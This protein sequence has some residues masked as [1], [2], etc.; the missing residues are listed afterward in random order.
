[1]RYL[2]LMV[3]MSG[4]VAIGCKMDNP[5]FGAETESE[6]GGET[7]AGK[8]DGT[9]TS[10][11][12][13][14]TTT[15]P[16][17]TDGPGGTTGPGTSPTAPT[18]GVTDSGGTAGDA[19]TGGGSTGGGSTGGDPV[20]PLD[21]GTELFVKALAGGTTAITDCGEQVVNVRGPVAEVSPGNWMVRSC[22]DS[23]EESCTG[24][25]VLFEFFGDP[26]AFPAMPDCA[27]VRMDQHHMVGTD[28]CE[29]SGIVVED[30]YQPN[31]P[32]LYVAAHESEYPPT[33]I[34]VELT[35]ELRPEPECACEEND[36]C[37]QPPGMY[38]LWFPTSES[39]ARL[40]QGEHVAGEYFPGQQF[41]D[42]LYE[43]HVLR[44]HAHEM[45]RQRPHFDWAILR[46]PG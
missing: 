27:V 40:K 38:T 2:G 15:G 46:D 19:S 43:V 45:C 32:P 9:S 4:L 37:S 44:A 12:D 35:P 14:H 33:G 25:E 8:T 31:Q 41:G 18:D 3:F 10:E 29:F 26:A 20:C 39:S 1:M 16:G 30:A 36:C 42:N 24:E 34:S 5:A 22:G 17:G 23:C 7:D 13:T 11:S 28:Q 21:E 6:G